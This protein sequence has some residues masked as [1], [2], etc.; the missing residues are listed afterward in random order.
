MTDAAIAIEARQLTKIYGSGNT[1][2]VAM[3]D[4]SLAIGT[5]QVVALLGPSGAG[6]ST[7]LTAIGLINPPT[8]GSIF[9][10]GRPVMEGASAL[11]DVRS[12]R[13]RYIVW[14]VLVGDAFDELDNGL[15]RRSTIPRRER[16]R[17]TRDRGRGRQKIDDQ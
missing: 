7:L 15:L 2:V 9:I 4:A 5:G 11:V 1:E 17:C 16:I 12:F 3:R 10:G 8:S 14:T 13:R 6:K